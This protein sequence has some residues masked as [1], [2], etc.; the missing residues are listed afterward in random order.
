[1]RPVGVHAFGPG[2]DITY[3]RCD[4]GPWLRSLLRLA[5]AIVGLAKTGGLGVILRAP[6]LRLMTQT[7]H[8]FAASARPGLKHWHGARPTTARTHIAI[9]ESLDCKNVSWLEKVSEEQYRK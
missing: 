9:Q 1:M 3:G 5:A 8:F 2:M 4:Y 6:A 7:R